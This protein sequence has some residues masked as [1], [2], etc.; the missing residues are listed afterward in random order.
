MTVHY[1]GMVV[2]EELVHLLHLLGGERLYH[3]HPVTGEIV[4]GP[5]AER[6]DGPWCLGQRIQE[7]RVLNTEPLPEVS[8]HQ[9]TVLFDFKVAWEVFFV[10]SVIFNRNFRKGPEVI[11]H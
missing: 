4:V 3:V 5:P 8:K 7:V 1:V 9:W 10:I 2:F 6:I 11:R